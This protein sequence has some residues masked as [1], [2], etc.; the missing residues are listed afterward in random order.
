MM[1]CSSCGAPNKDEAKYCAGCGKPLVAGSDDVQVD[2]LVEY[3][4]DNWFDD[5]V[6]EADE[7]RRLREAARDLH[8][9]WKANPRLEEAKVEIS[10]GNLEVDET[11]DGD[12][13]TEIFSGRD[14]AERAEERRKYEEE[15]ARQQAEREKKRLEEKEKKTESEGGQSW[16]VSAAIIAAIVGMTLIG[17]L[18]EEMKKKEHHAQ[19]AE[20][21]EQE[22]TPAAKHEAHAA[23]TT[24]ATATTTAAT[25]TL[26]TFAPIPVQSCTC[27][28]RANGKNTFV[29]ERPLDAGRWHVKWEQVSGFQSMKNGF[30]LGES[31]AGAA[32][33]VPRGTAQL[34]AVMACENE[35][36]AIVAGDVASAW[37]GTDSGELLW[38]R[39]LPAPYAFPKD[40][41]ATDI[42]CAPALGVTG[43]V[44][45]VPLAKGRP[46][47]LSIRDGSVQK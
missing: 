38:T 21:E 11:F 29:L 22:E 20:E 13:L 44:F 14:A 23:R 2:R 31:D 17:G 9:K 6:P 43:N 26:Q 12:E 40:A 41:G 46:I 33:S 4:I 42:A 47:A 3:L 25:R 15:N 8:A 35:I 19:A 1:Q 34:E 7:K 18:I 24:P 27:V 5:Q 10:E 45:T 28:S 39:K 32:T 30:W 37:S 36:V 16:K